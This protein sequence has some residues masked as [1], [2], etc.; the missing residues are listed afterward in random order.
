MFELNISELRK[1]E[2]PLWVA[3]FGH[4]SFADLMGCGGNIHWDSLHAE[5]LRDYGYEYW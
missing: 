2:R 1:G 4:E 5:W 3:H